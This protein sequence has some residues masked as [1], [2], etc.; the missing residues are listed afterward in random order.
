MKH[1]GRGRGADEQERRARECLGHKELEEEPGK[2]WEQEWEPRFPLCHRH[3]QQVCVCASQV[4][5]RAYQ[6]IALNR[7]STKLFIKCR[8]LSTEC[9]SFSFHAFQV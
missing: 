8:E 1:S 3:G 4:A 9:S 2:A 5:E 6:M 7:F